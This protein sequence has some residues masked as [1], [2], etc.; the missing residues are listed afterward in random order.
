[1]IAVTDVGACVV[2]AVVLAAAVD[3][4][5]VVVACLAYFYCYD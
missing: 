2:G 1:M 3:V 4:V 5:A